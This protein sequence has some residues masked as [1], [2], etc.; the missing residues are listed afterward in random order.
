MV[1]GDRWTSVLISISI[2]YLGHDSGFG[3][4]SGALLS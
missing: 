3:F 1:T 4:Q 2:I